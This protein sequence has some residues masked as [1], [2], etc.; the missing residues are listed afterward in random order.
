MSIQILQAQWHSIM[1]VQSLL[2]GCINSAVVPLSILNHGWV[3]SFTRHSVL[4]EIF[5]ISITSNKRKTT[6]HDCIAKTNRNLILL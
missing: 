5:S 3:E 2:K 1:T 4:L 6:L